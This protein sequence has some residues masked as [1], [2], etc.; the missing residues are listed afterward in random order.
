VEGGVM[1]TH[2][3][4]AGT[5]QTWSGSRICDRPDCGQPEWHKV[6]E[7]PA[8]AEEARLI[9]ARRIGETP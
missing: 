4:V 5:H 7:L 2:V 3:F 9:D 8:V 1:R 6:H